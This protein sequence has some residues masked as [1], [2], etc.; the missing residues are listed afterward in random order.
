MKSKSILVCIAILFLATTAHAMV[1][2][3]QAA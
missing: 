2:R 1:T 3:V